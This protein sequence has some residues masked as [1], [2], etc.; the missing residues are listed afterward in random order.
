[1]PAKSKIPLAPR[2]TVALYEGDTER[3]TLLYPSVPTEEA[4]RRIVRVHLDQKQRRSPK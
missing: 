2:R 4:I 3:L 1:M